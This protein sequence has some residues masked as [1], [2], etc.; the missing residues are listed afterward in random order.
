MD[1][2]R[3]RHTH[4]CRNV[5]HFFLPF[6]APPPSVAQNPHAHMSGSGAGLIRLRLSDS[7]HDAL[8]SGK[9]LEDV[10]VSIP[11]DDGKFVMTIGGEP[12]VFD[13]TQVAPEEQIQCVRVRPAPTNE[14]QTVHSVGGIKLK[15][16][17]QTS[18]D[19]LIREAQKRKAQSDSS[20]TKAAT[21]IMNFAE[22]SS[23][24]G[25]PSKLARKIV[26]P[27]ATSRV[28]ANSA[29]IPRQHQHG[30]DRG[31]IGRQ[32]QGTSTSTLTAAPKPSPWTPTSITP[33]SGAPQPQVSQAP[34]P[35]A[36]ASVSMAS[37]IA[38][39]LRRAQQKEEQQRLEALAHAAKRAALKASAATAPPPAASAA[40]SGPPATPS[41]FAAQA[42]SPTPPRLSWPTPT[43]M[44]QNE[45]KSSSASSDDEMFEVSFGG[46]EDTPCAA[47]KNSE[48]S[49]DDEALGGDRNESAVMTTSSDRRFSHD[50]EEGSRK[51]M[52]PAG[53]GSV[54]VPD[55]HAA[56]ADL[57]PD[58]QLPT[59]LQQEVFR[60]SFPLYRAMKSMLSAVQAEFEVSS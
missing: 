8:A 7:M 56:N 10:T 19:T 50:S 58:L 18:Q 4:T 43:T 42:A 15:C 13:V 30:T 21:R 29:A 46:S 39:Q 23:M 53:A 25:P 51:E 24:L 26:T 9:G 36:T 2:V 52:A 20:T 59:E 1:E 35:T 40:T 14:P 28:A 11:S 37:R 47:L 34:A 5:F 32:P 48:A 27:V 41:A 55:R 54:S 16:V 33:K 38:E 31:L 45:P 22:E 3:R 6:F 49:G 12:V 44:P 17:A 60:L 57:K